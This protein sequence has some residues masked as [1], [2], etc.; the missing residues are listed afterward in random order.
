MRI[1][2]SLRLMPALTAKHP[3]ASGESYLEV[4]V[5]S[6]GR[7]RPSTKPEESAK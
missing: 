4:C 5:M 7:K 2:P 1:V 3:R 6:T